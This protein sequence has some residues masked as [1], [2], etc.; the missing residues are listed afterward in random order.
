MYFSCYVVHQGNLSLTFW[1][2]G[3]V[4]L[5]FGEVRRAPIELES[6]IYKMT[7]VKLFK[8]VW[9]FDDWNKSL[10][11]GA[12]KYRN[13]ICLSS[14]NL[15]KHSEWIISL[16]TRHHYSELCS[17]I[18][19]KLATILNYCNGQEC[20][21]KLISIQEDA[22]SYDIFYYTSISTYDFQHCKRCKPKL[23]W[24]AGLVRKRHRYQNKMG[25]NAAQ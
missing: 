3:F 16:Y 19:M 22:F 14:L 10:N 4:L 21:E 25:R 12:I 15:C 7:V 1:E 17:S 11:W 2:I 18:E 6:L 5:A 9:G 23:K 8:C 24:S 20:R 13:V